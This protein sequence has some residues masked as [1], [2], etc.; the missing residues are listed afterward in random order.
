MNI[1]KP[2]QFV[3]FTLLFS[4]LFQRVWASDPPAVESSGLP[5][6][7]L[8]FRMGNIDGV[9]T[10]IAP[11][12]VQ[13]YA[14]EGKIKR[15]TKADGVIS[16][17][18]FFDFR[19]KRALDNRAGIFV[20]VVVSGPSELDWFHEVHDYVTQMMAGYKTVDG[21]EVPGYAEFYGAEVQGVI[22]VLYQAGAELT[23]PGNT[24]VP[25]HVGDVIVAI[26]D[27]PFGV[28]RPEGDDQEHYDYRLPNQIFEVEV[29]FEIHLMVDQHRY[30]YKEYLAYEDEI[31]SKAAARY[32]EAP[33]VSDASHRSLNQARAKGELQ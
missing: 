25:I 33:P 15:P 12:L 11:E 22:P 5:E 3:C 10:E 4:I 21:K 9:M 26:N 29:V 1:A 24:K 17:Q 18:G 7:E 20:A 2:A 6:T 28:F 16:L 27:S 8:K 23:Y 13:K 19:V 30:T 14:K 31:E 32:G